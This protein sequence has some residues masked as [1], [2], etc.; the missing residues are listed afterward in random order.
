MAAAL[1]SGH[2]T[3]RA[4]IGKL[5][6]ANLTPDAAETH[7]LLHVLDELRGLPMSQFGEK[8]GGCESGRGHAGTGSEKLHR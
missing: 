1:E 8:N 3:E 5:A 6:I 7:A 2:T 4:L